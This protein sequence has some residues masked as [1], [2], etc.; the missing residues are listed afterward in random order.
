M[1]H[2]LSTEEESDYEHICQKIKE[3]TPE[4]HERIGAIVVSLINTYPGFPK[5]TY[6]VLRKVVAKKDTIFE[7]LERET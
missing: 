2:P 3:E 5:N 6:P 4:L 7:I 1:T